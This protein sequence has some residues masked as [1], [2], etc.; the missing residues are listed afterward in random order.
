MLGALRIQTEHQRFLL[1]ALAVVAAAIVPGASPAAA[2]TRRTRPSGG[3]G[4]SSLVT[5]QRLATRT[6][7]RI[8]GASVWF[9]RGSSPKT[10]SDSD[11]VRKSQNTS[12]RSS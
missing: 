4:F 8:G 3:R 1:V 6:T 7:W 5:N 10:A 2:R 12:G 9:T 11:V